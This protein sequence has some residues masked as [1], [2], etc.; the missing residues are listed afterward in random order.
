ME[1]FNMATA[2]LEQGAIVQIEGS[3]YRFSRKIDDCWQLEQSK[4][5]RIVEY[6]EQDLLRMV[7]EERLTF[8]GSVPVGRCGPANCDLSPADLELAK[9]RRSYVLA[10]LNTPNSRNRLEG[11]IHDV[12]KRVKAPQRAPGWITVYRWKSR[13]NRAN[14]D[15][16]VLVDDTR[17]KGNKQSRYPI[18]VTEL[19]EQ[20]ISAKYLKS[21]RNSVQQTLEDALYRVKKENELRPE[22]DALPLPTRRLIT[23][24]IPSI[25]AFDKHSARYGHDSAVKEFRGVKGH[26]VAQAPLERAEIDHTLLDLMV[27]DDQTG[28]PLGRPSVTA[29]IDCTQGAFWA[30]IS[31]LIRRAI[32]RSQLV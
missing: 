21:T 28:L 10:V 9:L 27:V 30:Y 5:G 31:G 23:R 22:C 4:T 18:S 6:E 1:R 17:S 3:E 24:M 13:F 15:V 11:A 26:T 25:P 20:S 29:C 14:G 7:A 8:R 32:N 19:C 2:C 12:W 16:R